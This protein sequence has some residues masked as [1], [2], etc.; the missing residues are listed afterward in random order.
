[1]PTL[2]ELRAQ[3]GPKTR[4]A[5]KP[6]RAAAPKPEAPPPKPAPVCIFFPALPEKG[7]RWRITVDGVEIEF[8]VESAWVADYR[9]MSGFVSINYDGRIGQRPMWLPLPEH[10]NNE[11][12]F[13]TAF[14]Q[15]NPYHD[16]PFA[17]AEDW[18]G[19]EG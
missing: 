4:K 2:D 17:Q 18:L 19:Q 12:S 11:A 14:Y 10:D 8:A 15:A 16:D 7:S 6:K 5:A 3:V 1:M 13:Y 9:D